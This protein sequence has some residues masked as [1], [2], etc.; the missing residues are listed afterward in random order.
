LPPHPFNSRIIGITYQTLAN[1][2]TPVCWLIEEKVEF[3]GD[4]ENNQL[5]SFLHTNESKCFFLSLILIIQLDRSTNPERYI[6]I[7]FIA[8]G[9][10]G[11]MAFTF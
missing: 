4:W 11:F 2:E 3:Q 8:S 10:V 9:G 7:I 5:E 1:K 6:E